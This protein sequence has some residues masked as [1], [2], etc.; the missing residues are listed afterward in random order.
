MPT[1][2]QIKQAV[3]MGVKKGRPRF[4][5]GDHACPKWL[6]KL[7]E[8]GKIVDNVFQVNGKP[9]IIGEIVKAQEDAT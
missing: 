5:F 7:A 2:P 9:L 8:S 1:N 3:F 4:D 6:L